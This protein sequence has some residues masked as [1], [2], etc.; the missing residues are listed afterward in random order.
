MFDQTFFNSALFP[1]GTV[2]R[3]EMGW[4]ETEPASF[5]VRVPRFLVVEPTVGS[6]EELRPYERIAEGLEETI[7]QLH[8]A[9][10]RAEV[11]FIPSVETHPQKVRVT[12]P[13]KVIDRQKTSP[14]ESDDFSMGGRF[15]ETS[16]GDSRYE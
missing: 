8:A 16:L 7:R 3:L 4:E 14:G 11:R 9:G 5:E 2:T 15:G 6:G 10:V 12:L 13:W 1:S